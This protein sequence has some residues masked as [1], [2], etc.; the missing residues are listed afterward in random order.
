MR[1]FES[2]GISFDTRMFLYLFG[3]HQG[4]R[5][6]LLDFLAVST[7]SRKWHVSYVCWVSALF[8]ALIL[9]KC[10]LESPGVLDSAFF[11]EVDLRKTELCRRALTSE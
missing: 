9:P 5:E 8:K 10:T 3:R 4:K 1:R 6:S 7:Q 2:G 11:W